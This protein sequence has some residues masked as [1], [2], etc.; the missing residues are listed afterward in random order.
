[1]SIF[2]TWGQECPRAEETACKHLTI[3][4]FIHVGFF[5]Y[6]PS[7]THM[8]IKMKELDADSLTVKHDFLHEQERFDLSFL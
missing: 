7:L 8:I 4:G 5:F 1:M 2:W 6:F 3:T